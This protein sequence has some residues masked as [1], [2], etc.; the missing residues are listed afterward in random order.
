[1]RYLSRKIASWTHKLLCHQQSGIA[2]RLRRRPLS[3]IGHPVWR[4][5]R[6]PCRRERSSCTRTRVPPHGPR[7]VML[8]P[9]SGSAVAVRPVGAGLV[10]NPGTVARHGRCCRWQRST[11]S[12]RSRPRHAPVAISLW[13]VTTRSRSGLRCSRSLLYDQWSRRTTCLGSSAQPV[14]TRPTRHG[15]QGGRRGGMAHVPKR[16]PRGVPGR[17][18]CRSAPP[19]GCSTT[20]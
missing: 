16:W 5:S 3:C 8:P 4:R 17:L 14:A 2:R 13:T 1:M 18:V 12:S 10:G 19:S 15:R 9:A 11:R 7:R 20:C 6:P